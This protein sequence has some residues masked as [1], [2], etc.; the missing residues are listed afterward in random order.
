MIGYLKDPRTFKTTHLLDVSSY[1]LVLG[2]I[3]NDTGKVEVVGEYSDL[4]HYY[5]IFEDNIWVIRAISP[6]DGI[7]TFTLDPIDS[8]FSRNIVFYDDNTESI[9]DFIAYN[10]YYDFVTLEDNYFSYPYISV[11]FSTGTPFIE[12]DI[13]GVLF[14]LADYISKVR[15]LYG[16]FLTYRIEGDTLH[17]FIDHKIPELHKIDFNGS[18]SQ[19]INEVYQKSNISKVTVN[20]DRDYYLFEDGTFSQ[21]PNDGV[22]IK[23]EWG[24]LQIGET[25]DEVERVYD[26]FASNSNSHVIEFY[27]T[28]NCHF[29]DNVEIRSRGVLTSSYLT[30]VKKSSDDNRLY[31]KTGE[32]I[33]TVSSAI[34]NMHTQVSNI[35]NTL[36]YIQTGGG[37]PS[38]GY[39]PTSRKVNGKTLATDIVLNA[40]DVGAL[41]NTTVV[42]TSLSQLSDDSTH[43]LVTDS[44]K[45]K[46]NSKSDFSGFY[47]DLND[48]PQI[49]NV[50]LVNNK[51]LDDLNI[52]VKG[53]YADTAIS[54]IEIETILTM[55]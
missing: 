19:V 8:I 17:I 55:D 50:T 9:E 23:G 16:V 10:I 53:D 32:L 51:T 45:S 5:F 29:F 4:E 2:S 14:N 34:A 25:D 6:E 47:N 38:E 43:R 18:D 37:S 44:D 11:S 3:Y 48:K 28:Q 15:L 20:G 39:V 54:N 30:V 35:Q 40:S 52:Q 22:R 36:T 13:D 7:T 31:C 27:T 42:P 46:W 12:P 41:P 26:I 1:D 24:S 49:N 33:T 21:N